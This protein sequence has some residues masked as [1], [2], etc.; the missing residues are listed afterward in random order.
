VVTG[1]GGGGFTKKE[2]RV[3]LQTKDGQLSFRCQIYNRSE[4]LDPNWVTPKYPNMMRD[5]GL[6]IVIKGDHC[7]KYVLWIHHWYD[8][9]VAIASLAVVRRVAGLVDNLTGELLE[10]DASHLCACEVSKEDKQ[11]HH[12]LANALRESAPKTWAR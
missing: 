11:L 12:S 5:N 8:G 9:S 1:G 2:M 4:A 3:S 10:L 6:F 7:G